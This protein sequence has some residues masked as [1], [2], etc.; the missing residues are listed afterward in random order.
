MNKYIL[1]IALAIP[2]CS[3]V[4]KET[5]TES[6]TLTYPKGG[7]PH[8]KDMY[9]RNDNSGQVTTHGVNPV[10]NNNVMVAPATPVE[11]VSTA[12]DWKYVN[13]DLPV[14]REPTYED[15]QNENKLLLAQYYNNWLRE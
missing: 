9:L 15:I 14:K 13:P 10:N 6:R 8:I 1:I 7:Y 4:S 5:Y 3:S 11:P 2:A 12:D